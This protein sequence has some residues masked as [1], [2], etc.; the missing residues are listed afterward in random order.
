[1]ETQVETRV[2]TP[3]ATVVVATTTKSWTKI[4]G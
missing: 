3:E 1:V 2:E 4:D